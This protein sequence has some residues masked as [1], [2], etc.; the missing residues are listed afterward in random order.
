MA[1]DDTEAA[2]KRSRGARAIVNMSNQQAHSGHRCNAE[3]VS[4]WPEEERRARSWAD[5]AIAAE[6]WERQHEAEWLRVDGKLRGIAARRA[7]LDAEEAN[8][9]RYAEELKLWRGYACGSM[10][11]YMERAMGYAPHTAAERLR[12][13][14]AI[15]ELPLLAEALDQGELAHSA[16]R[17]L[18]RVAVPDTEEAWLEAARGKSLRE[19]EALVSGHKPG[20]LPTDETEPH[21]HRKTITLEVSPETYDLWRKLHAL[22]AEEH[23]QRLSDDELLQSVFRRAYGDG[24]ACTGEGGR[25]GSESREA[26]TPAYKIAIKQCPD[27]K[28]AWQYSGGRDIEIDPAVAECAACDAVHLGSLDAAA[29]ER[30][31]TTVTPRKREQ[32]LARDGHCCTVPGCRRNIGLDLH[33]IEYQSRGGGHALGNLTTLCDLH[34]RAVHFG[35]LVIRGDAPDRMTFT[36]RK[37]RDRRNVTDDDAPTTPGAS[38]SAVPPSPARA[39]SSPGTSPVGPTWAQAQRPSLA[40]ADERTPHGAVAPHALERIHAPRGTDSTEAPHSPSSG[41]A[42][43][44]AKQQTGVDSA[45]A[46]HSPTNDSGRLTGSFKASSISADATPGP[47][48][49]QAQRPSLATADQRPLRC[50]SDAPALE[51]IHASRDVDSTEAPHSPTSGPASAWAKQQTG[52]DSVEAPHSPTNDSARLTGSV[53][54]SSISADATPIHTP[55]ASTSNLL[56]GRGDA[57]ASIGRPRTYPAQPS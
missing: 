39:D 7:A 22:A 38:R 42:S 57:E 15:A 52:A 24:R 19:I 20:H 12:V 21:L 17:E 6:A 27:C 25:Q 46:P 48:W 32:V 34:H 29:P 11:E 40:T 56:N 37:P 5:H 10:I 47:T 8:L 26:S 36:F 4:A 1:I 35:K 23:G 54:V 53:E 44:C 9:L 43:A 45:E 49:A 33:H 2:A 41:P 30:T 55:R 31:T 14:R 13:A 18:S 16:V 3:V 28:R 51:R 50:A